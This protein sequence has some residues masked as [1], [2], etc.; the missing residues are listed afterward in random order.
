M[1]LEAVRSP[2]AV[3]PPITAISAAGYSRSMKRSHRSR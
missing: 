1:S 2:R 3:L